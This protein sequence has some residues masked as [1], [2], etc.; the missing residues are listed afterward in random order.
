M[1][2]RPFRVNEIWQNESDDD[3]TLERD[4]WN[5][6]NAERALP[7]VHDVYDFYFVGAA[8]G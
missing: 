8:G 5:D 6:E 1:L 2:Q 3:P 4:F 7:L